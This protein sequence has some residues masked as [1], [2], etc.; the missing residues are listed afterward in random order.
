M[1]G[2]VALID[3]SRDRIAVHSGGGASPS[4]RRSSWCPR[5]GVGGARGG[6]GDG[7]VE[8]ESAGAS[9]PPSAKTGSRTAA[10]GCDVA[11]AGDS[12]PRT[13]DPRY[14]FAMKKFTFKG[15]LDGFRSSVQAAPRGTEQE[16]QETLRPDH[17]QIKKVSVYRAQGLAD[18]CDD[19]LRGPGGSTHYA[20]VHAYL[21]ILTRP[22]CARVHLYRCK[23]ASSETL[24]L[25]RP[26][27]K[28]ICRSLLCFGFIA[29]YRARLCFDR[30]LNFLVRNCGEIWAL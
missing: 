15:V 6:S 17:F 4:F 22:R 13:K 24:T 25:T 9:D 11:G 3:R 8:A 18:N 14:E 10:D 28:T 29:G 2:C 5:G 23:L 12:G 16:I 30:V 1:C 20:R 27:T 26:R 19:G 7:A 21:F